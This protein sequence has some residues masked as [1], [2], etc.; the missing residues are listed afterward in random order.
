MVKR[1]SIISVMLLLIVALTGCGLSG[2]TKQDYKDASVEYNEAVAAEAEAK[3]AYKEA[4]AFSSEKKE[5]KAAYE[6][7]KIRT[8]AAK[9]MMKN[10]KS[11]N[12]NIDKQEDT[13]DNLT[14]AIVFIAIAAIAI[15][16][17]L[18]ILLRPRTN[19]GIAAPQAP[20]VAQIPTTEVAVLPAKAPVRTDGY[21][22]SSAVRGEIEAY[23]RSHGLDTD[24]FISECGSVDAAVIKVRD[25]K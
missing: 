14:T 1:L 25:Y 3:I 20:P 16:L 7:A 23:C 11:L 12:K 5:L 24:A 17:F 18:V 9:K 10:A 6:A 19:I 4:P 15:V 22:D 13:G 2:D 8:K 21:Y